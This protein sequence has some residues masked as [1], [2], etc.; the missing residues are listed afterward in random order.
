MATND[1]KNRTATKT[2]EEDA[3]ADKTSET[4]EPT[5]EEVTAVIS[6]VE[7]L[8]TAKEAFET[9]QTDLKAQIK[10]E[11][12]TVAVDLVTATADEIVPAIV[13][14]VGRR[15]QRLNSFTIRYNGKAEANERVKII[16]TAVRMSAAEYDSF[17]TGNAMQL[18]LAEQ[19]ESL[20][21]AIANADKENLGDLATAR[22]VVAKIEGAI[23]DASESS[24]AGDAG[25]SD[26]D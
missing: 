24:E 16:T 7:Q 25:E 12:K 9:L 13:F 20:A 3:Q 18:L 21:Q 22:A 6:A 19:T 1:K 17:K 8:A 26:S 15:G 23:L 11:N 2:S 10:T 14:A 5:T 4:V